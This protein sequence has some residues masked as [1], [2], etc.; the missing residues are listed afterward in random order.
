[1]RVHLSSIAALIP[2]Y[3]DLSLVLLVVFVGEVADEVNV[4]LDFCTILSHLLSIVA[5]LFALDPFQH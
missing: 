4:L 2:S 1:M 5:A 3:V